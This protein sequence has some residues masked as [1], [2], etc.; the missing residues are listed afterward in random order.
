MMHQIGVTHY[1][2]VTQLLTKKQPFYEQ[3]YSKT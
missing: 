3:G 1:L 2:N